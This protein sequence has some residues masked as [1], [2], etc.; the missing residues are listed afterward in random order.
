MLPPAALSQA[1]VRATPLVATNDPGGAGM[2]LVVNQGDHTLSVFDAASGRRLR[3]IDVG[4]ITGHEVAVLPDH[5]TAVVPIYGNSGVGKA[6]TDGQ[7]LSFID[8]R[9]GKIVKQLDFG[10]GV[11]PH[12]VLYDAASGKL[13]V[14]TELDR[15]IALVDPHTMTL[16]G[17]IPTGEAESHMLAF[18]RDG[19]RGYTANVH[20]GS[21]SVLD[22]SARRVVKIIPISPEI[23]R[24][25]L[26]ADERLVF[27]A[28]QTQPRL[29]VVDT[30][31]NSLQG[32]IPLPAIGYG[33]S[34]TE[35]GRWLLVAL[36]VENKLAVVDLSTRKVAHLLDV[37]KGPTEVLIRPGSRIA[38]VSCGGDGQVAEIDTEHWA[39]TRTLRSGPGADGLAWAAAP[40]TQSD[41]G[42]SA[43]QAQ[44]HG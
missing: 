26:S 10:H 1:S 43:R 38:Y 35:D 17:N 24:I 5:R 18:T 32:F 7:S 12:C 27:T 8:L 41:T 42:G 15:A 39:I 44:G 16:V 31:S 19:R 9:S 25:A 40:R 23:Q 6:G 36:R 34:S 13:L 2:L 14:T 33:M 28:D 11:R 22:L 30:A 20:A 4:G 29:A 3:T 37:P 21:V